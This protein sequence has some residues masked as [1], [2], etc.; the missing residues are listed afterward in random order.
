MLKLFING[1]V[2]LAFAAVVVFATYFTFELIP[3]LYGKRWIPLLV[4]GAYAS[5][6]GGGVSYIWKRFNL[7]APDWLDW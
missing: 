7:K 5:A 2:F 1:T 6:L 4:M 3:D